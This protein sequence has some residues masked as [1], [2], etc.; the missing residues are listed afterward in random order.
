VAG[1][2]GV[3]LVLRVLVSWVDQ[4]CLRLLILLCV[5]GKKVE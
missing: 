1:L 3:D 4:S 2:K 5:L